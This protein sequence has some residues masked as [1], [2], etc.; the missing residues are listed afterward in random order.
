MGTEYHEDPCLPTLLPQT[1]LINHLKR[2]A[3]VTIFCLR[4]QH[5]PLIALLK[6]IGT[7]ADSGCPL[8]LCP[9]ETVAHLFV[10]P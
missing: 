4:C 7:I 8:C 9:E 1:P 2:E 5:V 10:C 3:Q 6:R